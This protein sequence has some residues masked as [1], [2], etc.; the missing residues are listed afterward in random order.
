LLLLLLELLLLWC[1]DWPDLAA[2]LCL[3]PHQQQ[4]CS[5]LTQ[6]QQQQQ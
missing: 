3:Q 2:L 1:A 6:Y 5:R 4:S